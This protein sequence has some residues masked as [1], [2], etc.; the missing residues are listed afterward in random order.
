[1]Y[2]VR[3]T[4]AWK[5]IKLVTEPVKYIDKSG[6]DKIL[7]VMVI[8]THPWMPFEGVINHKTSVSLS[9]FYRS[10]EA[11]P[12]LYVQIPRAGLRCNVKN[13]GLKYLLNY[14]T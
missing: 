7:Q 2:D 12:A 13:L 11:T 9:N 6:Q 5:R 8:A 10:N 14:S 1:M 3:C 4:G